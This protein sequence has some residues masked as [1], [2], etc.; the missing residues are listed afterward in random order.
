MA[1]ASKFTVVIIRPKDYQHSDCFKEVATAVTFGIRRMGHECE[2]AENAFR[3]GSQ[4]IVFGGHLLGDVKL[5]D[6]SI[7]YNLEQVGGGNIGFMPVL[8]KR[9]QVWDYSLKNVKDWKSIGIEAKHVPF[10]YVPELTKLN[11]SSDCTTDVLFYG[12]LNER[13][14]KIISSLKSRGLN[15]ETKFGCYGV[16]LLAAMNKAKIILNVHYY[17][18]KIFEIVRVGYALANKKAVVSEVSADDGDY[19]HLRDGIKTVE[20]DSVVD[21]CSE[22]LTNELERKE[23]SS[24][25]FK[26]YSAMTEMSVLQS[27]GIQNLI[28]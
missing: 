28:R 15:V 21:A 8:A 16:D 9:S 23:I 1:K 13:R 5:P 3:I 20:Y 11:G 6:N 12:C 17:E 14:Q 26:A 18:S 22:L 27:A 19:A 4:H 25:G 7:L 24:K 10:C 2:M